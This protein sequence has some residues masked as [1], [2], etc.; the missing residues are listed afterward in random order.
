MSESR[1]RN[2]EDES[3]D[4][5]GLIA[6]QNRQRQA[7][8][9][10]AQRRFNQPEENQDARVSQTDWEKSFHATTQAGAL[11]LNLKRFKDGSLEGSYKP[12]DMREEPLEGKILE[13]GD[14]YL[15]ND[16]GSRWKGRFTNDGDQFLF[17]QIW[18][19]GMSI[20]QDWVKL[21]NVIMGEKPLDPV[22]PQPAPDERLEPP[23]AQDAHA[24]QQPVLEAEAEQTQELESDAELETWQ[25]KSGGQQKT[26]RETGK[27]KGNPPVRDEK[28]PPNKNIVEDEK[29]YKQLLSEV[30]RV[31]KEQHARAEAFKDSKT[32][33]VDDYR[34]WF[35]KVY[36]FVTE[37]EIRFCEEET[38][39]YPTAVLKDVLYFDK[40]YEDN[41]N[42]SAAKQEAHWKE[43]FHTMRFMQGNTP[44]FQTGLPTS[45]AQTVFSLVAGMLAH[46]RFDLPRSL[47]WVY[48]EYREKYGAKTDDFRADFFSMAGVFDNAT[49]QMFPEIEKQLKLMGKD[50]DAL[51]VQ[52]MS[53]G[54]L[55]TGAMNNLIGA[56]MSAE[57]L[58]AWYRM[59]RLV[60]EKKVGADPYQFENGQ[61]E[62]NITR[63]ENHLDEIQS[64]RLPPG[65]DG[66]K[67]DLMATL[68]RGAAGALGIVLDQNANEQV[69]N[70]F[71]KNHGKE[72]EKLPTTHRADILLTLMRSDWPLNEAQSDFVL[73]VLEV[74]QDRNDLVVVMDMVGQYDLMIQ[75]QSVKKSNEISVLLGET[76]YP[77]TSLNTVYS[78][79]T[80]WSFQQAAT[81]SRILQIMEPMFKTR[82]D[83]EQA[84]LIRRSIK[85]QYS[86]LVK[87]LRSFR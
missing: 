33:V 80:K 60:S 31:L 14:V 7:E 10:E 42:A 65:L 52:L 13:D 49:R 6:R 75:I 27:L 25:R 39:Y 53:Q 26:W 82:S 46:I 76:Y 78:Q 40:V 54:D 22:I 72:L 17:G 9:V 51:A 81:S 57:R 19:P 5:Y 87:I 79:L 58:H 32:G 41:L 83:T 38:Y 18:F 84:E 47:A 15:T 36:S 68:S 23:L 1:K 4:P 69:V 70:N 67:L 56:N 11:K 29:T 59:E 50:E 2:A 3:L 43:A 45:V 77:K 20:L 21:E 28:S 37:N 34:Y 71:I 24:E 61:L 48:D 44:N 86:L 74:S 73:K 8:E 55:A 16:E 64:I 12:Q 30:R 62:G 63:G 35:T 85:D 66:I